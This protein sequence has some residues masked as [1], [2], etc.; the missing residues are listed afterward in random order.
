MAIRAKDL[1]QTSAQIEALKARE[2][3]AAARAGVDALRKKTWDQL[4]AAEKD[5]VT[6]TIAIML[7]M[8]APDPAMT[9]RALEAESR[10]AAEGADPVPA[11]VRTTRSR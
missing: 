1:E 6:K 7:G 10:L 3:A 8:V 11:P 9:P 5:D 4:T 2:G